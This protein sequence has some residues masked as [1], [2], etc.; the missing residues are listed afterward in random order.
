MMNNLRILLGLP[1]L[2]VIVS[3]VVGWGTLVNTREEM[4]ADLNQA[5]QTLVDN[6]DDEVVDSLL[7]M[8]GN[9][10]LTF[11]GEYNGF[12]KMLRMAS[13]RDTAHISYAVVSADVCGGATRMSGGVVCSDSIT[14]SGKEARFSVRAYASPSVASFLAY[15]GMMFSAFSFV[16]GILFFLLNARKLY[17]LRV[18][19]VDNNYVYADELHTDISCL[20][21]TP[22]QEQLL[23]L[24]LESPERTL[25]K[26]R[27]CS[28]LWPKKDNPDDTF[29]TF[30]S[31]MKS[32]LARQS[33]LRIENRRGG[34]YVLSDESAKNVL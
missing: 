4:K 33:S 22:M 28:V 14:I 12:A 34:G 9:P 18:V 5:L 8:P 27:I 26:D 21:L 19:G 20:T 31:R 13:L 3:I 1:V 10:T 17:S 25:S 7:A 6:G 29:Y 16:L 23:Q 30:I 15:P 32:A 24:F 2:M 11:N